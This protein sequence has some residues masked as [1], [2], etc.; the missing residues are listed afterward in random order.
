MVRL[1]PGSL[2]AL[3]ACLR[4]S[5]ALC[6]LAAFPRHI[7]RALQDIVR[8]DWVWYNEANPT[9]GRIDW[10]IEPLDT[11]PGAKRVFAE[12]MHE[13]PYLLDSSRVQNGCT[14]RLSDA[15]PRG[16]FH[17]LK[18]YNEFYRRRGIE[19]Q[20]G[21]KLTA[22]QSLVIAVGVN[23]GPQDSDFSEDDKL[24]LNLLGPHLVA[25]YRN[26]EALTELR[27]DLEHVGRIEDL[28]RAL[29]IVRRGQVQWISPRAQ[30]LLELYF[31]RRS[32]RSNALPEVLQLWM[33][34]GQG[35]LAHGDYVSLARR[36]FVIEGAECCLRVRVLSYAGQSLLLLDERPRDLEPSVLA[37]LGLTKRETDVLVWVARGKSNG[38]IATILGA[39]PAT[40]A[41]HLEHVFR[42]LGVE[43]RTAAAARAFEVANLERQ[44]G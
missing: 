17:R 44:D 13:H 22:S 18:L 36:P 34:H 19:H 9:K 42:K 43:T 37:R 24:C 28:N 23:R 12:C 20:L 15:L 27:T 21:I 7:V 41:K 2:R 30:Q 32:R 39:R 6:D 14:W 33:T 31:G 4:E 16:P 1:R 25:A 38:D 29:V 26:A 3:L 40:V 10:V 8:A 11:L 5:Y 35:L